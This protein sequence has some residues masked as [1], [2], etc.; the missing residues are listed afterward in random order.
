MVGHLQGNKHLMQL[1][2]LKDL[3][4]RNKTGKSL[5]DNLVP[6]YDDYDEDYWHQN[7]GA[8]NLS[9]SGRSFLAPLFWCQ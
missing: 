6:T 7:K 1:K 8:R 5:N 9:C 4:I 3:E 2:R